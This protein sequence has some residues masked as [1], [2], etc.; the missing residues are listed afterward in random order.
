MLPNQENI[1]NPIE[2]NGPMSVR[3]MDSGIESIGGMNWNIV[4]FFSNMADFKK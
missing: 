2:Y 1:L 4:S 3:S